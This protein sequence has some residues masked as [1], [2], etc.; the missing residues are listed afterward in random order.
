MPRGGGRHDRASTVDNN[1]GYLTYSFGN[2]Y[3]F[4]RMKING[5]E[6]MSGVV[7]GGP[8]NVFR[9]VNNRI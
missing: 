1:I 7:N 4:T 9:A 8:T 5:N 2:P 3:L 6:G